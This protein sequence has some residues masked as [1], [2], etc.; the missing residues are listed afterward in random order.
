V[1]NSA[2]IALVA[3]DDDPES[4]KLI[5]YALKQPDSAKIALPGLGGRNIFRRIPERSEKDV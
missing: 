3:I 1:A 2:S 4:L 5:E